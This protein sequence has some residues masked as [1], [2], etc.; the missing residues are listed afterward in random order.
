MIVVVVVVVGHLGAASTRPI[1]TLLKDEAAQ[2][3]GAATA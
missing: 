2:A 1:P 3:D